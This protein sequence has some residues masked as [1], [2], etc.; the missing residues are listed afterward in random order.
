MAKP[1]S[2]PLLRLD[3]AHV[4]DQ[5]AGIDDD[6]WSRCFFQHIYC[7]FDDAQFADLYQKGGRS[8]ISPTLLACITILQYMFGVSDRVAV[9]DTIMRR[10]RRIALGRD[11]DRTGFDA[12]VLCN[13]RKRLVRHDQE[14]AIF[15]H[16]LNRLRSLG[17][18]KRRRR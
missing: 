15:S 6:H 17:L 14:R 18:L 10:D 4:A 3:C 12:S 11:D 7:S 1:K 16:V 2:Q 13:F 5:A 9:E 8:P